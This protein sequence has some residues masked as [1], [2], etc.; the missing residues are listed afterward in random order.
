MAKKYRLTVHF[1]DGT[2]RIVPLE[3]D[4]MKRARKY[5]IDYMEA[6]PK[7]SYYEMSNPDYADIW[8]VSSKIR[9]TDDGKGYYWHALY[10]YAGWQRGSGHYINKDG[11]ISSRKYQYY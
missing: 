6:M 1:K 5:A 3:F 8:Q 10:P 2:V 11:S 7:I 9:R 4:S